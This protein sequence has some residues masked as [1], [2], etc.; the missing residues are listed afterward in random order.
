MIVEELGFVGGMVVIGLF[1]LLI[2]TI[3]QVARQSHDLTGSLIVI[4]VLGMFVFQIFENIGM[5]MN[6]MP[7][8]GITLPFLSYGGSSILS[9]MIAMGLVINVAIRNRGVQ[10]DQ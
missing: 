6:V 9:N 5:T 8:T 10:L 4:G 7:A 2:Y 3:A 1:T